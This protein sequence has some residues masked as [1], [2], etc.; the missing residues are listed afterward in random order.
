[1]SMQFFKFAY[2]ILLAFQPLK[3]NFY[4]DIMNNE[5]NFPEVNPDDNQ[6]SNLSENIQ[7]RPENFNPYDGMLE[8]LQK[9]RDDHVQ[10]TQSYATETVNIA[11]RLTGIFQLATIIIVWLFTFQF[12]PFGQK[13]AEPIVFAGIVV[14]VATTVVIVLYFGKWLIRQERIVIYL[15]TVL[16]GVALTGQLMAF[17]V[18]MH[19]IYYIFL[20][21]IGV[22]TLGLLI[23]DNLSVIEKIMIVFIV[24]SIVF[25]MIHSASV[26]KVDEV[27][28]KHANDPV[29]TEPATYRIFGIE[30]D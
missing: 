1:M 22:T 23:N 28:K 18:A 3:Y 14:A 21:I 20:G 6:K 9:I 7:E 10:D 2:C 19:W 24:G 15:L 26:L 25:A 29:P 4:G 12:F 13:D 5:K 30:L 11:T 17:F 16:M 27:M 8:R